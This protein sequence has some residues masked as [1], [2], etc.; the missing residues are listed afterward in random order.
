TGGE[1]VKTGRLAAAL[2]LLAALPLAGCVS[3]GKAEAD[4]KAAYAAGQQEAMRRMAQAHTQTITL[5]GEVRNPVIPWTE[6]MTLSK[7][8]VG[9][10]YYGRRD[11][12]EII[13]VRAGQGMRIDPKQ[14]LNSQDI[15]LKAGDVI[16][17]RNQAVAP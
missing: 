9:A 2:M 6:D 10:E 1:K 3:K 11:P 15:P 7:A 13:L 4:A 16:Q 12:A 8:S 14:L 17:L 5:V